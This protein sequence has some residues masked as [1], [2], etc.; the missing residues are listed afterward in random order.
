MLQNLTKRMESMR[1]RQSSL[2]SSVLSTSSLLTQ[3]EGDVV[4]ELGCMIE[5]QEL[6]RKRDRLIVRLQRLCIEYEK[7]MVDSSELSEKN[8]NLKTSC[9]AVVSILNVGVIQRHSRQRQD[10]VIQ[11]MENREEESMREEQRHN[12]L[13]AERKYRKQKKENS[14]L[15]NIYS[16]IVLATKIDWARKERVRELMLCNED[17]PG[18]PEGEL[19]SVC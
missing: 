4:V 11:D 8:Q 14:I 10:T 7:L 16:S 15:R 17:E 6:L 13:S 5:A 3:E 1:S 19:Q 12:L 2:L 18:V 9:D